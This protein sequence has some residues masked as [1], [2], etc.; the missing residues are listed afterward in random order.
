MEVRKTSAAVGSG[1]TRQS[2]GA[3]SSQAEPGNQLPITE[4]VEPETV[5]DVATAVHGC[6][7]S[8]TAV[9]PVGGGTS[10]DFGFPPKK[11]GIRLSLAKLTRVIDYPA[12]DMTITVESGITMHAMQEVLAK[13]RQRLA[14][15]VPQGKLSTLGGVVATN[16]NGPRRLGHGSM[17][18][19]VI[20]ISAVDGRGMPFKGGGRV[21]KNVAGYDFCKLLTGSHGSIGVITQLTLKLKPVVER[22]AFLVC[23]P[24]NSGEAEKILAALV[25]S[26]TT[27][28][29]AE[30]LAGKVWAADPA[31]AGLP[32]A[33]GPIP[34]FLAVGLEGTDAEVR[35]MTEQLAREWWDLGVPVH[36]TLFDT[37]AHFLMDRCIE[38]PVSAKSPMVLKAS[39][40]PSG[41]TSFIAAAQQVD[42]NCAAQAHAGN[43]IVI[44]R[45]SELPSGGVAKGLIGKLQSAASAA[46]GSLVV[47]SGNMGS[48]ATHQSIWGRLSSPQTLLT[49]VKREFDPRNILNPDRFVYGT[50]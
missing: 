33:V 50:W 24:R 49:A 35:W 43:G 25:H 38:F 20:G 47:L 32:V 36:H 10:L 16:F 23:S 27:P 1:S 37:D 14:I 4:T 15:D 46:N 42:P 21:V 5:A 44:L 31:F 34:L 19:Y 2:L 8:D 30:L 12:R 7:E 26:R 17:R 6:F 28:V 3:A 29:A 11:P 40:L 9:Y 22:L 41:V 18:D 13:E 39:I 45:L 48:D